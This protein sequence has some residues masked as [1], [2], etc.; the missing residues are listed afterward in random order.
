MVRLVWNIGGKVGLGRGSGGKDGG[1]YEEG[2]EWEERVR[3]G[4][5]GR[6]GWGK[7]EVIGERVEDR[8]E[9]RIYKKGGGVFRRRLNWE[10]N[11]R[12]GCGWRLRDDVIWGDLD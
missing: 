1:D 5:G 6:K 9:K 7:G 4:D 12:R 3:G 11:M 2:K 10:E 8:E